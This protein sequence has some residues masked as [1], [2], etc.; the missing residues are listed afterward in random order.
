MVF[1][2]KRTQQVWIYSHWC[3]TELPEWLQTGLRDGKSRWGDDS[4]LARTIICRVIP[5]KQI[6]EVTGFGISCRLQD[7]EYPI[8]VV[9]MQSQ[10]VFSIPEEELT[11]A[12]QVPPDYKPD[13]VWTFEEYIALDAAK[14]SDVRKR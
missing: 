2:E 1:D 12:G 10:T 4:Y 9:D 5:E 14:L 11:D 8:L 3:G 6:T 7:N 13:E